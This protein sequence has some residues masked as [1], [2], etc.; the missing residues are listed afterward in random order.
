MPAK[1]TLTSTHMQSPRPYWVTGSACLFYGNSSMV[2][3]VRWMQQCED[4]SV[5]WCVV[6]ALVFRQ[7]SSEEL[8]L[9]G[10]YLFNTITFTLILQS[11][12]KL[13]ITLTENCALDIFIHLIM[14]KAISAIH[15]FSLQ[16]LSKRSLCVQWLKEVKDALP[17]YRELGFTSTRFSEEL[18]ICDE[19]AE[20]S[21]LQ[22]SLHPKFPPLCVLR[23][24]LS[25]TWFEF[26]RNYSDT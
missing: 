17:S 20:H 23:C 19:W 16:K 2:G 14:H 15:I 13:L 8:D 26:Q 11:S 9:S 12:N 22:S 7:S 10:F 3:R 18:C 6:V 24:F 5:P 4:G 21:H 25:S 1:H